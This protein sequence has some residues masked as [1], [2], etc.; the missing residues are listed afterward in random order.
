MSSKTIKTPEALAALNI[1][2]QAGVAKRPALQR[3][4]SA[5]IGREISDDQFEATMTELGSR[6]I[7][8][9]GM[10]GGIRLF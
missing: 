8:V 1:L 10:G 2:R 9:R 7:R 4:I 5:A 3:S 6:I